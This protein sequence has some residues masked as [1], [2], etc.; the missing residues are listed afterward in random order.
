MHK[1][2]ALPQRSS[3]WRS[4]VYLRTAAPSRSCAYLRTAGGRREAHSAA[5]AAAR[6]ASLLALVSSHLT[7]DTLQLP[8]GT[9]A[10][11]TRAPPPSGWCRLSE[12]C[13]RKKE[14]RPSSRASSRASAGLFLPCLV[15]VT[16]LPAALHSAKPSPHLPANSRGFGRRLLALSPPHPN[17]T[18]ADEPS[19]D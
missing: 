16:V 6:R 11:R 5:V 9:H 7:T 12:P 13:T 4:C 3:P 17:S 18:C 15:L 8:R 1:C 2:G 19:K 14:C 10:G